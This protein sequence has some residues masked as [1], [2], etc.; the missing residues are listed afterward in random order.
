LIYDIDDEE[1]SLTPLKNQLILQDVLAFL[2]VHP[3]SSIHDLMGH[4]LKLAE[5]TNEITQETIKLL[6]SELENFLNVV[7]QLP[8]TDK[9]FIDTETLNININQSRSE[10]LEL[11][12]TKAAENEL[13]LLSLYSYRQMDLVDWKPFLKAALERNPVSLE[14]LKDMETEEVFQLI[15]SLP[16]ES[17]YDEK[18]LAQPDEVWNFG[19]GDGIE[20]A[21]L[22][23]NFLCHK[24]GRPNM[25]LAI[26]NSE[27]TL[28]VG[29][30]KYRFQSSKGIH[31]LN[32][33]LN[34]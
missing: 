31:R 2:K 15:L 30:E 29:E 26:N 10:I 33:S 23:A 6:F 16:N 27:V 17:I 22:L 32:E 4:C 20:K 24:T 19:R 34:F 25:S 11:I 12:T 14:G 21:I 5:A 8:G 13:A 7:P 28:E 9:Q 1:F 18:R 3:D